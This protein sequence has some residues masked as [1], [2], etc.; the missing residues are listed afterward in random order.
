MSYNIIRICIKR[1]YAPHLLFCGIGFLAAMLVYALLLLTTDSTARNALVSNWIA[2][3]ETPFANAILMIGT[4]MT[5]FSILKNLLVTH[6]ISERSSCARKLQKNTVL[7][8]VV[9]VVL[10]ILF[11][12]LLK[13]LSI[14]IDGHYGDLVITGYTR[15]DL[16][17]LIASL[18]PADIFE[19]F[20]LYSP[21]SII[22]LSL[23]IILALRSVDNQFD[24]LKN[25]VDA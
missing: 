9:A 18:I 1:S 16:P 6:V 13:V 2:P 19:P 14:I 7:T 4:P 11:G 23:L 24:R 10:A 5:F 12:F 8:S 15:K 3:M 22:L 21:Y 20:K 25:A 17:Q